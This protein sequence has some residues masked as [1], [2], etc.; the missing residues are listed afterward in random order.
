MACVH[1]VQNNL[2]VLIE[3]CPL[4]K[5]YMVCLVLKQIVVLDLA[6]KHMVL[7]WCFLTCSL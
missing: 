1:I 6:V 2:G 7:D 5:A 4:N 3:A